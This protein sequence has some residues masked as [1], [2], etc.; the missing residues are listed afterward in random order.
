MS[1][2]EMSAAQKACKQS[3]EKTKTLDLHD[4][5]NGVVAVHAVQNEVLMSPFILVQIKDELY[6]AEE[7]SGELNPPYLLEVNDTQYSLSFWDYASKLKEDWLI[8]IDSVRSTNVDYVE[9]LF[10]TWE[11]KGFNPMPNKPVKIEFSDA[12]RSALNKAFWAIFDGDE[13]GVATAIGEVDVSPENHIAILNY[14]NGA[15]MLS[16]DHD[17]S[18]SFQTVFNTVNQKLREGRESSPGLQR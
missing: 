9:G 17:V 15:M 14:L 6:L 5:E 13:A 1:D 16:N 3:S 11:N 2:K 12:E 10:E 7:D 4:N 8:K 18:S